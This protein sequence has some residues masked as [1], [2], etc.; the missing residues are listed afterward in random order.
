VL[1]EID[2]T[3]RVNG[4]HTFA[5]VEACGGEVAD[6]L[7]DL[8]NSWRPIFPPVQGCSNLDIEPQCFKASDTFWVDADKTDEGETCGGISR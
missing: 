4:H 5:E 2:H 6:Y 1:I 8:A 3:L 7:A